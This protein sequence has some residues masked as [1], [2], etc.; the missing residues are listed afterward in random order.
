MSARSVAGLRAQVDRLASFVQ[1]RPELPPGMVA[2][3][4]VRRRAL[5]PYRAVGVGATAG[6]LIAGLRTA[7][8]PAAAAAAGGGGVGWLFT[9]QGSQRQGMGTGLA[10]RFPVFAAEFTRV[11]GLLDEFLPRPL[12][13]VIAEGGPLLD[14]TMYAQAAVFAVQV[15]QV[16][17]L[18]SFGVRPQVVLGHSVG[19][20]AAAVTAGVLDMTDACRLVA[21]RGRLMDALPAGGAMLAVHAGEQQVRQW[22]TGLDVAAVNTAGQVVLSGTEPAVDAAAGLLAGYGVRARRLRVSHAFHSVLME[23]MLAEFADIAGTVT[24]QPAQ[25]PMLSSVR[26]GADVSTPEYWVRHVRDTVRFADAIAALDTPTNIEV[27]P[28]ATL[29]AMLTDHRIS[30]LLRRDAD[31]ATTYLKALGDLHTAGIP[32]NWEPILPATDRQVDLPTYAFQH[33]R[34]WLDAD[35]ITAHRSDTDDL[36]YAESWQPVHLPG[37]DLAS[38]SWLVLTPS[39]DVEAEWGAAVRK[40]IEAAGGRCTILEVTGQDRTA[41]ADALRGCDADRVVSL[42]GLDEAPSIGAPAVP[43]GL[44]ATL[45][46]LQ[47][48]GDVGLVAPLWCL[49]RE[50]VAAGPVRAPLQSPI[51]GLG[52]TAAL[53]HPQRWGGLIDVPG[54]PG[55]ETVE[56]LIAVVAAGIEDQVAV[57][58]GGVLARRLTRAAAGPAWKSE[59]WSPEGDVWITGGT[60]GVGAQLARWLTVRGARSLVLL[61]RRGPDAPGA[62]ELVTEL[63]ARGTTATVVACDV[64]DRSQIAGLI[65]QMGPPSAVFHTAGVLD[66]GVLES[67]TTSRLETVLAAKAAAARHLDELTRDLDLTAFVLFGSLAGAVGAAGQANYAAANA[68]LEALAAARH[69]ANRRA[70]T[71]SWGAWAGPGMADGAD[72]MDHSGVRPMAPEAALEALGRVLDRGDRTT[73]IADLDWTHF[74]ARFTAARPSPLLHGLI[75]SDSPAP[76]NPSGVPVVQ[77]W[78]SLDVA[79]Q[80]RALL[81]LILGHTA[82][83]LGHSGPEQIDPARPFQEFGF[84]SLSAVELRNRLGVAVGRQLPATLVFDHPSPLILAGELRRSTFGEPETVSV[85]GELD[86]LER[87]LTTAALDNGTRA[88]LGA[89]LRDL[90]TRLTT[91]DQEIG[92]RL[93]EDT[94]DDDQIFDFIE[95]QLGIS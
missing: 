89:R 77:Q 34:Y 81:D 22:V 63:A 12:A 68:Y 51:W 55:T 64:A 86:R 54:Q 15:A 94:S 45:H 59:P 50:A 57:R 26:A 21:A 66:D 39:A 87:A 29:T 60:G 46:L 61:S 49:T 88:A 4:L 48:L 3:G 32:I 76:G 23:P 93:P 70:L 11:C 82:A 25:V 67:L 20:F 18:R 30:P 83:V 65:E 73:V 85:V 44:T 9:G 1:A 24:Y 14:R 75:G 58:P 78:A 47:A 40:G 42:L 95:N 31:E 80:E 36:L 79:G 92:T 72:S 19:E 62:A 43:A 5:L 17:L 33:Q 53:E 6:E 52:R 56:S 71:V 41:L 74:G 27:G 13:Q 38:E 37:A 35:D 2:A 8:D 84:T 16:A 28:D 91:G 10:T 7:P 90:L 69:A